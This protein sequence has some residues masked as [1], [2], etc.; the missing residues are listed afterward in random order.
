MS[1]FEGQNQ[2]SFSRSSHSPGDS[3]AYQSLKPITIN[4]SELEIARCSCFKKSL[5]SKGVGTK[6]PIQR[7][8]SPLSSWPQMPGMLP[9]EL[10][11]PSLSLGRAFD[12][13]LLHSGPFFTSKLGNWISPSLFPFTEGPAR[14]TGGPATEKPV[15]TGFSPHRGQEKSFC[16]T[17]LSDFLFTQLVP[18]EET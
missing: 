5:L 17:L 15:Q 9:G 3:D 7:A 12:Q 16:G 18:G 14:P 4:Q 10:V 6:A 13:E 11:P 1:I 8:G 2:A